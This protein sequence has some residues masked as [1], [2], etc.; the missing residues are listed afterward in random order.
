MSNLNGNSVNLEFLENTES[1]RQTTGLFDD[2]QL[3]IA[4]LTE[5][6]E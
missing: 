5:A 4:L 1:P 2:A 6:G 3:Y